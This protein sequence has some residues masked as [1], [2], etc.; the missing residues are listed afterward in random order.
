MNWV[1]NAVRVPPE[2]LA[3]KEKEYAEQNNLLKD[4]GDDD[5]PSQNTQSGQSSHSANDRRSK[6]PNRSQKQ[7]QIIKRKDTSDLS[8]K[9]DSS[10]LH[11]KNGLSPAEQGE[12]TLLQLEAERRFVMRELSEATLRSPI[13]KVLYKAT[14]GAVAPGII[15]L[16]LSTI[17]VGVFVRL[18]G[19]RGLERIFIVL[20]FFIPRFDVYVTLYFLQSATD[21]F[22]YPTLSHDMTLPHSLFVLY[23]TSGLEFLS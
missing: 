21:L 18:F 1:I 6:H 14:A 12:K 20:I 22:C 8:S 23:I 13:I 3:Q 19:V 10:L 9:T 17:F 16:V 2:E 4:S 5:M 7:T 15:A 11:E